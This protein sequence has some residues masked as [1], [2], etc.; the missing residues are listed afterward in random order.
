MNN[1]N[2]HPNT[3]KKIS[4]GIAGGFS[5]ERLLLSHFVLNTTGALCN[6]VSCWYFFLLYQRNTLDTKILD[7]YI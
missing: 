5:W 3:F 4:S 2:V 6:L 7:F 1:K